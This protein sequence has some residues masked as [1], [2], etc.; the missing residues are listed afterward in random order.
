MSLLI[1]TRRAAAFIRTCLPADPSSWLLLVGATFLFISHNL[2]WWPQS[3]SYFSNP[4]TW[5]ICAFLMSFPILAAGAAA[6]Y[7]GL[8]GSKNPAR[9]LLDSVLLPA[10]TSLLAILIVAFFWFRNIGEPAYFVSQLPGRSHLWDPHI[11]LALAV[12]LGTGFQL[13]S[14]G[15]ILVAAFFILYSWGRATLPIHLPSESI[16]DASS[17]EDEHRRSMRF[18]WMMIAIVFL[19]WVPTVA[20]ATVVEGLFP[21]FRWPRPSSIFWLDRLVDTFSLLVFVVLVVGKRARKMIP[22]MLRI[23]RIKYLTIAIVIPVAIAYVG[24][25]ASYL[26]S[27]ILWTVHFWGKYDPP[28]PGAYFRL[29][30]VHSLWYFG[31][32]LAEEIAWRGFLQPRFIRRYGLVRGIFLVGVVWGAF[33]FF[34]DF[35]SHLTAQAIGIRLVGRLIGTVCLSYALAWLTIRSESILPAAA[36]HACYNALLGIPLLP[37][38]NPLW[39]TRLLWAI[40]GFVLFYSFPPPSPTTV[41]ESVIPPTPEP[42]PSEV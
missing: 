13:A 25:L 23:P 12:N 15:F 20:L 30:N 38:P 4:V 19:A 10:A 36:A 14:L 22:A 5:G 42:E 27:R 11:F 28:L 40:A 33:H 39:L 41:A 8:L 18:V 1:I 34:W 31:P 2:R 21:H 6:C 17:P 16:S 32:A 37:T 29:P 3:S 35:N 9:R 24:P 26:H 7:L